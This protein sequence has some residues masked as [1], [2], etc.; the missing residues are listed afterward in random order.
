M[1][2][3]RLATKD[4]SYPVD[5]QEELKRYKQITSRDFYSPARGVREPSARVV[6]EWAKQ[7]NLSC[8]VVEWGKDKD[9][10][11]CKVRGWKGSK[12]NPEAVREA[13]VAHVFEHMLIE[14]VIDAIHNGIKIP[15][16]GLDKYG[17]P[18][19]EKVY[20]RPEK[21]WT[22]DQEKGWPVI[23]NHKVQLQIFKNHLEKIKFA[24]RD[25]RTK[26]ERIVFLELLGL[27]SE[28]Q[29]VESE[30]AG[31]DT[32]YDEESQQ[33]PGEQAEL[34]DELTEL[35]RQI[36]QALLKLS[37]GSSQ[38]AYAELR[39]IS[40]VTGEHEGVTNLADIS[41][42]DHARTILSRIKDL[43]SGKAPDKGL[44]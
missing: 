27:P 16:G 14:A 13:V 12:E 22:V 31:E 7:H 28:L 19:M 40:Q 44:L 11:W 17:R 34:P 3:R 39:S 32:E 20:L 43:L 33:R 26:A 5:L 24:E 8:E 23:T 6:R 30:E 38:K 25:A 18:E 15:T 2:E 42:V 10:A 9:K 4:Q 1:E 21:D 41:S 29:R 37:G 35:R 36:W